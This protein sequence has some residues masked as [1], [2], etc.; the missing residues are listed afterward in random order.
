MFILIPRI[1]QRNHYYLQSILDRWQFSELVALHFIQTITK[2]KK[3]NFL[4]NSNANCVLQY[5][6]QCSTTQILYYIPLI[7]TSLMVKLN[8]AFRTQ[9]LQ[10][11]HNC[12]VHA[13]VHVDR[14]V[15][16]GRSLLVLL[17]RA[18][19]H[20]VWNCWVFC[21]CSVHPASI[22]TDAHI[23]TEIVFQYVLYSSFLVFYSYHIATIV[24]YFDVCVFF[25]WVYHLLGPKK[26]IIASTEIFSTNILQHSQK[27]LHELGF[28]SAEKL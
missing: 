26:N 2:Y 16:Q 8:D 5:W 1:I 21:L 9:Y 28:G 24:F 22:T 11:T 18:T 27:Y 10:T 3:K 4:N 6:W 19:C 20:T 13:H 7:F 12:T 14:L 25:P 23:S 15:W 17:N